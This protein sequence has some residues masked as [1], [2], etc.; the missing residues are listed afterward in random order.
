M[1]IL[2]LGIM[3]KTK[4]MKKLI[5]ISLLF[6]VSCRTTQSSSEEERVYINIDG[7]KIELVSDEFGNQYLKQ[8]TYGLHHIYIPFPFETEEVGDTLHSY[9]AKIR[10]H[11]TRRL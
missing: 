4:I 8:N 6:F 3:L 10:P 7:E 5:W 9:E 1:D 2:W 11:G